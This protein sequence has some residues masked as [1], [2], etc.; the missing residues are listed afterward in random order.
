MVKE[1][2]DK[3]FRSACA[4]LALRRGPVQAADPG[5][6]RFAPYVLA[7][8]AVLLLGAT[9]VAVADSISGL[10]LAAG[11]SYRAT[12]DGQ[13]FTATWVSASKT[14]VGGKDVLN[15]TGHIG[16]GAE[17]KYLNCN[18]VAPRV[19]VIPFG[20]SLLARTSCK[21]HNGGFDFMENDF[22]LSSGSIE[23][24][25]LDAAA[26]TVS[27]RFSLS[28][29]NHAHTREL[30]AVTGQFVKVPID[31]SSRLK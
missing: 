5:M 30:K 15:V 20:G 7:L 6:D 16:E 23:I 27:G 2:L 3:G 21:F 25:A 9:A 22:D 19:G 10:P 17:G 14:S 29:Q 18:L 11:A 4:V 24:T 1:A 31:A 26:N 28:G 12:L 8:L 13:N